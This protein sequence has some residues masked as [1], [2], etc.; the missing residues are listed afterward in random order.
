ML[1]F[2]KFSSIEANHVFHSHRLLQINGGILWKTPAKRSIEYVKRIEAELGNK[3]S[4]NRT[5]Q[6]IKRCSRI[7]QKNG[8]GNGNTNGTH[9]NDY[10]IQVT[11]NLGKTTEFDV[12]VFACSP[13]QTLSILK[14]EATDIEKELLSSFTYSTNA[15]YIHCD[16]RLM[17][18]SKAAWTSWNFIGYSKEK[19]NG[20]RPV[21]VSYWLNKLQKFSHSRNIFVSLNPLVK[22]EADKVFSLIDYRHPQFT[23]KSINAQNRLPYIQGQQNTYYCG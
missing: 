20:S 1:Y 4:Y 5:I 2:T 18:K 3:I 10:K 11:D 21:Y 13:D 16:E 12:I 6:S 17:P 22:P 19:G 14:D 8:G 23:L 15:T 7:E 9:N